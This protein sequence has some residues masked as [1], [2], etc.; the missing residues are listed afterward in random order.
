MSKLVIIAGGSGTGKSTVSISLCKKYGDRCT[1]LHLDDYFKKEAPL[2]NNL[3]NWEDP[4]V[5]LFDK[6][7]EDLT[8]LMAGESITVSTKS[9]LYN[10]EYVHHQGNKKEHTLCS[11]EIIILEGYLALHD[12]RF[13]NM[14]DTMFYLDAPI[15]VSIKR[16]KGDKCAVD[17]EYFEKILRPMHELHVIPT[18]KYAHH[19]VD[20]STQDKDTVFNFIEDKIGLKLF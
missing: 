13:R 20:V 14:A 16:R 10:P 5:V 4:Q 2:V 12:E 15:D 19:T 1:L 17:E 7:Y 6:L 8:L 18:K 3:S 11:K 9:E